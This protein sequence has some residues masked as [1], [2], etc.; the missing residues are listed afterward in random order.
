MGE[1]SVKREQD[2]GALHFFYSD[3]SEV[4]PNLLNYKLKVVIFVWDSISRQFTGRDVWR[5]KGVTV[6]WSQGYAH[7]KPFLGAFP[8]FSPASAPGD[9]RPG[10]TLTGNLHFQGILKEYHWY[11]YTSELFKYKS[12]IL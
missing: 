2:F 11:V 12:K 6:Q 1:G 3:T 5:L 8:T 7:V 10:H 4:V 9:A